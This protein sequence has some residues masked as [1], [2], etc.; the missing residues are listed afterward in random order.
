MFVHTYEEQIE[1]AHYR[2]TVKYEELVESFQYDVSFE[3]IKVGSR[4]DSMVILPFSI[5]LLHQQRSKCHNCL[6][7]FVKLLY[8]DH[9]F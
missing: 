8:V 1:N 7:V 4:N 6:N 5:V 2:K 9:M 3:A